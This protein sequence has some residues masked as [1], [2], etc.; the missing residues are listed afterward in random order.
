MN[1]M[2]LY[3]VFMALCCTVSVPV[4]AVG[5]V[6][7]DTADSTGIAEKL[8]LTI[9]DALALGREQSIA[10]KENDNT[11]LKAEWRY[12]NYKA[13]LL[14]N[15][16][17]GGTL[18]SLNRSLNSYQRE[19]GTY[20]FIPNNYLSETLGL[21]ISQ[22][23]PFTGGKVYLETNLERMDQLGADSYGNYLS[24]PFSLTLSQPLLSYNPY[25]WQ[26]KTEPMRYEL[27]KRE[28][29]E[30]M[31]MVTENVVSL[32][33][34]VLSSQ[35]AYEQSERKLQDRRQLYEMSEKRFEIGS[36]TKNDL[37][38]LQL[39]VLNAEVEL[40]ERK[41]ELNDDRFRL[42]SFL[43][44]LSYD[45]IELMVPADVPQIEVSAETV[46]QKALENS[47]HVLSQQLSILDSEKNLKEAKAA[48]GLQVQLNG[49]VGFSKVANH[50]S[51]AFRDMQNSEIVGVTFS[52]PLFDWG[53]S[54]GRV[55]MAK[56]NLES[57][58]TQMEQERE[59]YI[60]DIR[61]L[62]LKFNMQYS[63]CSNTMRARSIAEERYEI[64]KKRFEEGGLTVTEL[65]TA[66]QD[67]ESSRSQYIAQLQ[68][69]WSSYYSLRRI[70]LYDWIR[71]S[72]IAADFDRIIDSE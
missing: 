63:Q 32:F 37:L 56:A 38:Q 29:L 34:S 71:N 35:S 68:S 3:T 4:I 45:D 46:V 40:N 49:E 72:D 6:Q 36:V 31:E 52:L 30:N 27:A 28:Y 59:K 67:L 10:S 33:F 65:N 69:F 42:F 14:P 60:Q 19:D 7:N 11:L 66:Q 47:K 51:E 43:R 54:K 57:V 50:F 16:T 20:T 1:N 41:V 48:K 5:A 13:G 21:T 55:R 18:P 22:A 23:I 25:R 58:R 8:S 64:T 9:E 15:I 70:T 24:V 62:A 12:R 44:I 2:F 26:K 39:S 17:I 53:V 61:T